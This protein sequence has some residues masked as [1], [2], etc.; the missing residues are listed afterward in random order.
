MKAFAAIVVILGILTSGRPYVSAVQYT[1]AIRAKLKR[2]LEF[3]LPSGEK[4]LAQHYQETFI[5][6][7]NGS[8][9]K[10][11]ERLDPVT[12][13]VIGTR[14][15]IERVPGGILYTVDSEKRTVFLTRGLMKNPRS[16]FAPRE[17]PSTMRREMYLGRTCTVV[18]ILG[19]ITG[20]MW[21]D[22]SVGFIMFIT[23]QQKLPDG[24]IEMKTTAATEFEL[25]RAEPDP[26]LFQPPPDYA[27]EDRR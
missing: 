5:R 18:P 9:H 20:E 27:I 6:S 22:D 13:R 12:G 11:S 21:I 23:A 4:Q 24:R 25:L 14:L 10:L 26:S 8:S 1:T 16:Y 19:R 17:R 2:T 3:V 15:D 7:A